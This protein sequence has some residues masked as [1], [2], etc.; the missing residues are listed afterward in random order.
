MPNLMMYDFFIKKKK[1]KELEEEIDIYREIPP[2]KNIVT[3]FGSD[4][5][6]DSL[7][8]QLVKESYRN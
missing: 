2:H 8:K 6:K 5:K 4:K 3:Y 7:L 1:I